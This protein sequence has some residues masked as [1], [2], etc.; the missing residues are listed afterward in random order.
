MLSDSAAAPF[1]GTS[2]APLR[3]FEL[4]RFLPVYSAAVRH[5]LRDDRESWQ[6][7]RHGQNSRL[8]SGGAEGPGLLRGQKHDERFALYAA[9]EAPAVTGRNLPAHS[10]QFFSD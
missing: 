8:C 7:N 10:E 1:W 9:T 3:V 5:D 2:G 4:L 6:G